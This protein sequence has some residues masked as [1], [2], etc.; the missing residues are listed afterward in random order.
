MA[1][2]KVDRLP[3]GGEAEDDSKNGD[4]SNRPRNAPRPP[5]VPEIDAALWEMADRVEAGDLEPAIAVIRLKV[6]RQIAE[7]RRMTLQA[8]A[9]AAKVSIQQ[10][11]LQM[12]AMKL[13]AS[14]H[15]AVGNIGAENPP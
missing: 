10:N 13:L 4:R 14:G 8:E 3:L 15:T 9:D 5:S 11:A 1:E 6:A 2:S 12:Q 7:N